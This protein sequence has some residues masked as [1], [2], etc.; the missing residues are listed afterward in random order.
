VVET[1]LVVP[2]NLQSAE[3]DTVGQRK[4]GVVRVCSSRCCLAGTSVPG[5]LPAIFAIAMGRIDPILLRPVPEWNPFYWDLS[6]FAGVL[7]DLFGGRIGVVAMRTIAQVFVASA[8]CVLIGRG[9]TG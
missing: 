8:L 6:V 4:M 5:P 7:G 3:Y 1:E 2:T 9:R